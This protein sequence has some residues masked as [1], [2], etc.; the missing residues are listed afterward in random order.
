MYQQCSQCASAANHAKPLSV[1]LS[2]IPYNE[3]AAFVES[4]CSALMDSR[5]GPGWSKPVVTDLRKLPDREPAVFYDLTIKGLI[6]CYMVLPAPEM[7][8]RY[9][10][11]A[12]RRELEQ[13]EQPCVSIRIQNVSPSNLARGSP[14]IPGTRSQNRLRE[15]AASSWDAADP[16]QKP[17]RSKGIFWT[18]LLFH[19]LDL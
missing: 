19:F 9:M 3:K 13:Y 10:A 14:Q 4:V 7:A 12:I 16:L 8:R 6:P 17:A 5:F 11:E 15:R 18:P 1:R 2:K